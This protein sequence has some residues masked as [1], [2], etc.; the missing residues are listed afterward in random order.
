MNRGDRRDPVFR[1]DHDRILFLDT[2]EEACRKT[3]WRAHAWCLMSNHFH[4]VIE[5]RQGNLVA[6]IKWLLANNTG[7]F[8]RRH[9]RGARRSLV[10]ENS[11]RCPRRASL[12]R[13]SAICGFRGL[14]LNLLCADLVTSTTIFTQTAWPSRFFCGG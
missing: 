6:G 14:V 7:P 13:V 10:L 5:T 1:D 2:L 3:G 4:L 8:N 12:I 11:R 9:N